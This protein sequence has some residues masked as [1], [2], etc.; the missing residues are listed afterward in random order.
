MKRSVITIGLYDG[1]HVGHRSIIDRVVKEAR[2]RDAISVVV[3]FDRHPSEVTSPGQAPC[4]L[5]DVETKSELLRALGIDKIVMI[6]FSTEIAGLFPGRFLKEWIKPLAPELILV[7]EDFRF[8]KGRAGDKKTL[9]DFA[10]A[11]EYETIAVSLTKVAGEKASSSLARQRISKGDIAGAREILGRYPSYRGKVVK[12]EARGRTLGFPTANIRTADKMCLPPTSVY[13]GR[14]GF[15]GQSRPAVI[16]IGRAPTFGTR[17]QAVVEA[18][19]LDF[20]GDL[21]GREVRVEFFR[22][23]RSEK[24]FPNSDSLARQIAED[25]RQTRDMIR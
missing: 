24:K 14:L 3:T 6:P 12:G 25:A 19:V 1:V 7:G 4:L 21:Y 2:E 11:G 17:R 16:N 18:Y 13:A 5:T 20:T 9:R 15:D 22:R 8:G 23:L 10:V